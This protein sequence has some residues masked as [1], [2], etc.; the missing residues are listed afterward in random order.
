MKTTKKDAIVDFWKELVVSG[1]GS[2][3]SKMAT[4]FTGLVKPYS[5][6]EDKIEEENPEP[7]NPIGE[8]VNCGKKEGRA[9]SMAFL[10]TKEGVK[11][12]CGSIDQIRNRTT[13]M[14]L[15]H[16]IIHS[17]NYGKVMNR[18]W[19]L[20]GF[21]S[22]VR[23]E[24]REYRH[25][26]SLEHIRSGRDGVPLYLEGIIGEPQQTRYYL[27]VFDRKTKTPDVLASWRKL[28]S[29]YIKEL[30]SFEKEY[31]KEIM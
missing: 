16:G 23:A 7:K 9:F 27:V 13:D 17:Y 11:R 25:E 30:E 15:C 10:F 19:S 1:S 6:D 3:F 24:A 29:S 26:F 4:M 18:R 5:F 31:A 14:D 12:F 22:R 20:F 8:V 21:R 2:D 28:P